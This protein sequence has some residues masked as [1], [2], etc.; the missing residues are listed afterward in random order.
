MVSVLAMLRIGW[1]DLTASW[2]QNGIL[3]LLVATTTLAYLSVGAYQA[4]LERLIPGIDAESLVVQ[5]S[6]T[7]GE[8]AGSR[9]PASLETQLAAQGLEPVVPEIHAVV[10]TSAEDAVLLRG[11]D[12]ARFHLALSFELL[13]GQLLQPGEA[14]RQTLVGW[15]L[16][17]RR[18]LTPGAQVSLRGRSFQVS[19]IFRTGTYADNEAWISLADAQALLGWGDE[20]SI[21][22][23]PNGGSLQPGT[24]LPG[25][26]SVARRGEGLQNDVRRLSPVLGLI[27]DILQLTGWATACALAVS[28]LRLAWLRR[29]QTAILRCLGFSPAA[30][31]AYLLAQS[32]VI[33]GGGALL[34]LLGSL[35]LSSSVRPLLLGLEMRPQHT[36][37]ILLSGLAWTAGIILIGMLFPA[38][39]L[40][41]LNLAALLRRE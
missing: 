20:V 15:R 11:I 30:Q 37:E 29:R 13:E 40:N 38:V 35:A 32:A 26:I 5:Q 31:S 1:L 6:H 19:G 7:T 2:K 3:V 12:P 21:F 25:G 16:A 39:W 10:G 18:S 41:R 8:I 28:L 14:Q 24:D 33:A 4:G 36:P 27:A 23:V 9:I 22:I 17:E 34:G